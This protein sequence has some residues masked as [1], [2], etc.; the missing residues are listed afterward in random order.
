MARNSNKTPLEI[1]NELQAKADRAKIRAVQAE[2][3]HNPALAVI[4]TRMD[5]IN[6]EL[7][8]I[9]RKVTGPNSFDFRLHS[10]ELRRDWVLAERD[11]IEARKNDLIRQ[12]NSLKDHQGDLAS[13]IAKGDNPTTIQA[14]NIVSNV[15][16]GQ[17]SK[18]GILGIVAQDMETK[19]REFT[20]KSKDDQTMEASS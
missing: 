15:N 11:Y 1:A 2:A 17:D 20:K 4:Q 8:E 13:M 18:V 7:N 19:W 5:E 10:L 6:K 14:Q 12:R 9:S 16:M 3:E